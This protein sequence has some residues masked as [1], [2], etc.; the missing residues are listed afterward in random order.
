[1]SYSVRAFEQAQ[2]RKRYI[3]RRGYVGAACMQRDLLQIQSILSEIGAILW[4]A[5]GGHGDIETTAE[6][7]LVSIKNLNEKFGEAGFLL[8]Q[9]TGC[10]GIDFVSVLKHKLE[11]EEL[12]ILQ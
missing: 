3:E 7:E 1:M 6:A 8:L 11:K 12:T 4:R 10:L 5:S 9:L 2:R